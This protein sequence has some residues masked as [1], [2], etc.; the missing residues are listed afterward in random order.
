VILLKNISSRPLP[1]VRRCSLLAPTP[2]HPQANDEGLDFIER[3]VGKLFG[4]RALNDPSPGGLKRLS[5]DEVPEMYPATTTEWAPPLEGD[6]PDV[7]LLRPLLARTQLERTPLRLAYDSDVDGWS[8]ERFHGVD[9]VEGGVDGFGAALVVCETE[10]GAVCGG[11][12]PRGWIGLGEDRD[13]IAAF[14]FSWPDGDTSQRPI[15]LPKV[16]GPSLAV[17]GDRPGEGPQFGAEGL[18]VKMAAGAERTAK[19]RL[20]TFYARMP[21]KVRHVFAP[22][23]NPRGA[24]LRR[25][26]AYVGVGEGEQWELDGIVWRTSV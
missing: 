6:A 21:G 19:S 17:T 1:P 16:G 5:A 9:G 15:K 25:L 11:Y 22:Q 3:A 12:N 13:A 23:E 18:T 10:G 24:Q 7:A 2:R 14:L 8:G 26:R 4:R 20:G